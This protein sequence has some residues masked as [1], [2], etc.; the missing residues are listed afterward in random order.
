M[1]SSKYYG[2]SR[3]KCLKFKVQKRESACPWWFT[4]RAPIP[5]LRLAPKHRAQLWLVWLL[6]SVLRLLRMQ[7]PA[8]LSWLHQWQ[9]LSL[10]SSKL[11]LQEASS[12]LPKVWVAALLWHSLRL[13]GSTMSW[14]W[15]VL[16]LRIHSPCRIWPYL[17]SVYSHWLMDTDQL[18]ISITSG[19]YLNVFIQLVLLGG[20][21]VKPSEV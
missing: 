14:W 16:G 5:C 15:P 1:G 3:K 2:P 17:Q 7:S 10:T 9:L 13:Q 11:G 4:R 19:T 6:W 12:R 8:E 21:L 18:K 20:G